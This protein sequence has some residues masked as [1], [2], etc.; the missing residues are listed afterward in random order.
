MTSNSTADNLCAPTDTLCIIKQ[1][2]LE[3]IIVPSLLLLGTLVTL[4]AL[5]F[6]RYCPERKHKRST[7]PQRYKS[8]SHKHTQRNSHRNNLTGIDAPPG[9]NPLEHEELPMSVQTAQ[10]NLRPAPAAGQQTSAERQH[11]AF[12]QVI[13]LPLALPRKPDDTVSLYRARMNNTGVILRMLKETASTSEEQHFLGFASF[14]SELG[15]HP[16]LP[17]LLGV[18]SVQPPL[19]MVV[20][21]LQHRDL[22]GFLWKCRK[23]TS[24]VESSCD[25]TEKR[26]FTMA[27]QVA[28]A[29]E[30]LHSQSCIHGNVGAR[31]ILV[32]EDLTAKLWGLGSAYRRRQAGSPGEVVDTEMRKWQA[33][34]VLARRNVSQSSD[35]WSFGILLYEMV[36]L[37]DPPF[38][39]VI[40]T[41]LL[42]YLQRGKHLKRPANCSNS[43]YSIIKS[44]CHWSPQQ[45]L[46]VRE[47]T[48]KLQAGEKS[49]NGRTALR[50]HEPIDIERYLREAGY[51]EAYNY[52]VL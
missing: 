1:R 35:V 13:A 49:A 5:C 38:A 52:A 45:R 46:S 23:E 2:E 26:I 25:M 30:Y 12:S 14:V 20:E 4:V 44:C 36:T 29:L 18:V 21:E 34:E 47:L 27:G 17:A 48:G 32:G 43:L 8:S 19:M 24:G 10:Q 16:F 37:G 40:T 11:G 15:P 3:I 39:Q 31:S 42:Q 28:S 6:L 7:A 41:E 33:P 9:L 51:E 50:V 22:L